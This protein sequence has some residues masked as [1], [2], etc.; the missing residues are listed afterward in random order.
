MNE[1]YVGTV[2]ICPTAQAGTVVDEC[3]DQVCVLLQNGDLWHGAAHQVRLPQG[4]EDLEAAIVHVD[5]FKDR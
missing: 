4:K 5:R 2:V 3:G 1:I